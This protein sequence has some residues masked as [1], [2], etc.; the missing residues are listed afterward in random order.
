MLTDPLRLRQV[1]INLVG[2]AIKFTDLG[3]VC[4]A[5]RLISDSNHPHLRFDV[6]DSGIGMN[7]EQVKRLFHPFTQVDN[8]STRAFG[9]T[10]LGLCISKRL[11]EALGGDIE[12]R[13]EPGKGSAF[14]VTIDPGPLDGIPLVQSVQEASLDRPPTTTTALPDKIELQGRVLMAEDGPDNQRLISF[15]LRNAGA[16][17]V[18]VENGQ[19]AVEQALVA[20][21]QERPFEVILMDMQMPVVDGYDAVRRLRER[22]YTG[23]IIALTAHAMAGDRQKCL[24]AGCDDFA[25]KPIDRQQLLATLAHWIAPRSND[26]VT[27]ILDH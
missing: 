15:L 11:T 25:T 2:N 24:D 8:S 3:V 18:A 1:L 12:V 21:E 17:V 14:R 22:G 20:W 4:L 7:E 13:S 10:G 23:P 5:V 19:L 6:T 9:G 16:D 26:R 27:R